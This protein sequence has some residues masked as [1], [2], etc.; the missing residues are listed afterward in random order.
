MRLILCRNNL[1]IKNFFKFLISVPIITLAFISKVLLAKLN[2]KKPENLMSTKWL[3][4]LSTLI[5][6]NYTS[7]VFTIKRLKLFLYITTGSRTP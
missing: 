2:L 1:N 6:L 4:A 5:L 3:I 7:E